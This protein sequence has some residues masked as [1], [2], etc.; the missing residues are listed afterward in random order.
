M[1]FYNV[2]HDYFDEFIT[3]KSA[4]IKMSALELGKIEGVLPFDGARNPAYRSAI[5]H[6]VWFTYKTAADN[7]KKR[8]AVTESAGEATVAFEAL[9]CKDLH[10]IKFQP[11]MVP[12]EFDGAHYHH[13]PYL[14]LTMRSGYRRL[15]YVRHGSSLA[16]G[17][18]QRQIRAIIDAVPKGL[19]NDFIVANTDD[20]P[21]QRRENVFRMYAFCA[22]CDP[23]VDEAVQTV[24]H[25]YGGTF[26]MLDLFPKL[27]FEQKRIF[28]SCYRLLGRKQLRANL[29]NVVHEHSRLECVR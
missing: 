4:T 15:V 27:S 16:R 14:L 23:E 29:N 24:A 19:A 3:E 13:T 28:Q 11:F 18:T 26:R 22:E 1:S 8:W 12:Y 6:R 25:R 21:R 2:N 7:F 5:S 9:M 17:K 10:D 20:F